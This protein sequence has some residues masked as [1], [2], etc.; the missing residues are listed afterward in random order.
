MVYKKL[1]GQTM[2]YGLG[3]VVPRFLNYA[4]MTAYYT[5]IFSVEKFGVITELYAY[6][7]FLLIILTYGLETALFKFSKESSNAVYSTIVKTIAGTTLTYIIGLI[8]FF[9][10][11][12][13]AIQ[14]EGNSE[15]ILIMG[16]IVAI[17]AFSS[18]PFAYLRIKERS[19]RFSIL[20]IIN[21]LVTL[22]AVFSFYEL[23]PWLGKNF[24][25]EL[26]IKIENNL[27]FVLI[28]NLIGSSVILLLLIPE[29]IKA[30]S[31]YEKGTIKEVLLYSLPLMISGLAGVINETLDRLLLKQLIPKEENPLYQLGIYGANYRIA[32]LLLL[33]IQM[34]RYAA[35]PF[36]F[37]YFG[38]SDEKK[39]FAKVMRLSIA[40]SMFI[41]LMIL[42]YL[43]YFKHF[44]DEKFHAGLDI[45][46]IILLA[47]LFYAVF[48]NLS[49]WYKLTKRTY[50]GAVFTI[51]GAM[52]TIIINIIFIPKYYYYASA[53]GHV[54]SYFTMSMLSFWVGRKY[55]SIEYKWNIIFQY[56][57]IAGGIIL[58]F[59]YFINEE[60]IWTDGLKIIGLSIFVWF[61]L[62]KEGLSNLVK[63]KLYRIKEKL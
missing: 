14:Y 3:T 27:I 17:D 58:V 59:Q 56:V 54:I 61:V 31:R 33:F 41:A 62:V 22:I 24:D 60:N 10:D 13:R 42:L 47:Y 12:A 26:F 34:F 44:I 45:V 8:V 6:V 18:I 53:Y 52:I 48:F 5:R 11:I 4:V 30:N 39:V 50:F 7:T 37:N 28:S 15:Y 19:V 2:L 29:I 40:V 49:I 35:E 1:A 43:H 46:P 25:I 63:D 55:Y 23:L 21:V 57:I 38:K 32:I 9:K 20:K 16:L 36:F 51:T